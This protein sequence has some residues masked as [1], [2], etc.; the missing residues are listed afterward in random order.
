[1]AGSSFVLEVYIF[2]LQLHIEFVLSFIRHEQVG[3]GVV[4]EG[5]MES[6]KG[7]EPILD[8]DDDDDGDGPWLDVSLFR[9]V[10][11]VSSIALSVR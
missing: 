9:T 11:D 10:L 4:A 3:S 5:G 1:L 8:D 6:L 7:F 2:A